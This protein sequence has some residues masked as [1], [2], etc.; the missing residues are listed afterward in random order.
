MLGKWEMRRTASVE[1]GVKV[2]KASRSRRLL[3]CAV[4]AYRVTSLAYFRL[5]PAHPGGVDDVST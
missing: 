4:R 1:M 2:G 5:G 3:S